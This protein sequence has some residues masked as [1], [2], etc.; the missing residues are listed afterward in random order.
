M[1]FS[2]LTFSPGNAAK[3]DNES[4]F[5]SFGYLCRARN[6]VFA[7][8]HVLWSTSTTTSVYLQ[9]IETR[10]K[11]W[12]K[13][14]SST[15]PT[16]LLS[17]WVIS[18]RYRIESC[19]D[20]CQHNILWQMVSSVWLDKPRQMLGD[21]ENKRITENSTGKWKLKW[22]LWLCDCGSPYLVLKCFYFWVN[23]ATVCTHFNGQALFPLACLRTRAEM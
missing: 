22:T 9:W 23:A 13:L 16:P 8:D 12:L 18:L 19:G 21:T 15:G 3:E 11:H 20:I 1:F 14:F 2:K 17:R 5:R 7:T 4:S 6:D 10:L